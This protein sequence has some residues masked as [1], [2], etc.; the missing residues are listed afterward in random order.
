MGP[1]LN[2]SAIITLF[3]KAFGRPFPGLVRGIGDDCAVF[4]SGRRN[5]LVTTDALV[6]GVHFRLETIP[7]F[8]LGKKCLAVNLSDIAAMGGIP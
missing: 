7:P 4:R 6:E 3:R 8:F 2:E 5:W 1:V